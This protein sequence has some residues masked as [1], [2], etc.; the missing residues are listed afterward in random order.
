MYSLTQSE[1]GVELTKEAGELP[2][3]Q[4]ESFRACPSDRRRASTG[5]S[6]MLTQSSV[7]NLWEANQERNL[8]HHGKLQIG[9]AP[10]VKVK[11]DCLRLKVGGI[12]Y[13]LTG[14]AVATF[15]GNCKFQVLMKSP[16]PARTFGVSEFKAADESERDRWVHAIRYNV[17]G[18]ETVVQE[19]TGARLLVIDTAVDS[20]KVLSTITKK[21]VTVL[22]FDSS[23]EDT[24][25]LIQKLDGVGGTFAA[26]A[27]ANH[28]PN[29][30]YEWKL[31]T[32][33][34][35][36][37]RKKLDM[38][39]SFVA[40]MQALVGKAGMGGHV[41][42]LACNLALISP[43]LISELESK[44]DMEF[45]A[46]VTA[47]GNAKEGGDWKMQTNGLD[48]ASLYFKDEE[49]HKYGETMCNP[50]EI[51][52]VIGIGVVVGAGM[53]CAVGAKHAIEHMEFSA[54]ASYSAS[55]SG[56]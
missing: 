18:G 16:D 47:T 15:G 19:D 33:T 12:R 54:S 7:L 48:A 26:V 1:R 6:P 3:P 13:N 2:K 8:S 22:E 24:T 27:L 25:S 49:V 52:A 43:E 28:G 50:L 20:K 42:L 51:V 30:E 45:S 53:A 11:L 17:A 32:D 34:A 46:S 14:A 5:K 56:D 9:E 36:D 55:P 23:T 44:M 21:N 37:V 39:S 4:D 29:K 31:T 41:D 38:N 10:P 35:V 40:L